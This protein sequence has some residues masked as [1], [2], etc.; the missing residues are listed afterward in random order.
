[1]PLLL[2][3]NLV[4]PFTAFR[5]KAN[6]PLYVTCA[7]GIPQGVTSLDAVNM[8]GTAGKV[9]V[10]SSGAVY[11]IDL[12]VLEASAELELDGLPVRFTPTDEGSTSYVLGFG[13]EEH[14]PHFTTGSITSVRAG[15]YSTIAYADHGFSGGPAINVR[16]EV[17]GIVQ[18]SDA[19]VTNKQTLLI[20]ADTV[21]AFL[22]VSKCYDDPKSATW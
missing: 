19:G 2:K 17:V 12:A 10:R 14:S 16:G 21:L 8:L 9:T 11:G 18:R 13:G 5:F 6:P 3:V 1:M 4:A 22:K 7:H 15:L 20:T